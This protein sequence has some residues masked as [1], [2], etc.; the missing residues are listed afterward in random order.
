MMDAVFLS[1]AD[2]SFG[3]REMFNG[4][5][6]TCHASQQ[7]MMERLFLQSACKSFIWGLSVHVLRC[8][9]KC[10]CVC[11]RERGGLLKK[12]PLASKTK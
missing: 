1:G 10:V 2:V 9:E 6:P 5:S 7:S 4:K 12:T 8:K 11:V 3:L